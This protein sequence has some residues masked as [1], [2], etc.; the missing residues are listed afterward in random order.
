MFRWSDLMSP[1][2]QPPSALTTGL[3]VFLFALFCLNK[4]FSINDS[5][6]LSPRQV[7]NIGRLSNYPLA[8]VSLL[9]LLFNVVSL[10][11]PLNVFESQHGT[12]HTGVVLNL[13]AVI[14]GLLYCVFGRLFYPD[15]SIAGASGWCF[16]LFGYFSYKESVISP[17]Y[18][19]PNSNFAFPTVLV[20]MVLLILISIFVPGVSFWGHFFALIVGYFIGAKEKVFRKIMPPS[21]IIEKIEEKAERLIRL[22]PSW[23]KFYREK[24]MTERD[25]AKYSSLFA[26]Q[27]PLPLHND[28]QPSGG[29]VLGTA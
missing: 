3:V 8:H 29:R 2:G 5:M 24:D 28:S 12:V 18:H 6:S 27:D 7:F 17:R 4:V 22:I 13:T 1:N 23:V 20:P 16:T 10:V 19:I 25:V 11:G 21:W 26:P 9:H 14:T 15:T